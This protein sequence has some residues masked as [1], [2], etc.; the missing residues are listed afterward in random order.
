MQIKQ[1]GSAIRD[2]LVPTVV[3]YDKNGNT[4]DDIN[5]KSGITQRVGSTAAY[6]GL[7][8]IFFNKSKT[9][10]YV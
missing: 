3:E 1:P 5:N 10:H 7:R 4:K 6:S 2:F 9:L 8:D